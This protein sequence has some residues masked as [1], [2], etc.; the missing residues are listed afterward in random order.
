MG[1]KL[2]WSD[3]LCLDVTDSIEH[4]IPL[5]I[6]ILLLIYNFLTSKQHYN[7]FDNTEAM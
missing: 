6:H 4:V 3:F 1:N 2:F 7:D 5:I